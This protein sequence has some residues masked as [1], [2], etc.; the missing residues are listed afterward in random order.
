MDIDSSQKDKAYSLSGSNVSQEKPHKKWLVFAIIVVIVTIIILIVGIF[1]ARQKKQEQIPET[2]SETIAPTKGIEQ[3]DDS[4]LQELDTDL[5]T[6][7]DDILFFDE[8]DSLLEDIGE[9]YETTE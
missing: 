7:S 3:F 1:G 8:Q 9:S 4:F 6:F 5:G 2:P